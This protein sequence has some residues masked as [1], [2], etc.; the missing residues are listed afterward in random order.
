MDVYFNYKYNKCEKVH[1]NIGKHLVV[2]LKMCTF[3]M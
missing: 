1:K 3:A 2:S